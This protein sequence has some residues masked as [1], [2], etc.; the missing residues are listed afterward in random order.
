MCMSWIRA[1]DGIPECRLRLQALCCYVEEGDLLAVALRV[2]SVVSTVDPTI[3]PFSSSR[4]TLPPKS[5]SEIR[6]A[7]IIAY[8]VSLRSWFG[9]RKNSEA[10]ARLSC[11]CPSILSA[12]VHRRMYLQHFDHMQDFITPLCCAKLEQGWV[13]CQRQRCSLLQHPHYSQCRTQS[14]ACPALF[15]LLTDAIIGSQQQ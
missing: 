3:E 2:D 12:A 7:Y 11:S 4:E 14:L 1:R 9:A 8:L 6:E 15:G 10:S 5:A 13:R